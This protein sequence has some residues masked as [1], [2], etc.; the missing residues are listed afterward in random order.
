MYKMGIVKGDISLAYNISS[1][2]VIYYNL[3]DPGLLYN[4]YKR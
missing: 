3:T 4:Y 1:H 2:A